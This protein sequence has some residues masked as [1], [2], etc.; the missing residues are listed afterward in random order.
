MNTPL[1]GVSSYTQ[2]L[3]G[4]IPRPIRSTPSCR[5]CSA[6]RTV[7]RTSWKSTT[8]SRTGNAEEFGEIQINKLL[9]DTLQLLEPQLRKSSIEIVKEY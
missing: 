6:R 7:P 3:L 8:F 1:T 4:L 2:M 5:K 9:N